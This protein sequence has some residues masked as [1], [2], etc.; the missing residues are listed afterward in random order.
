[1]AGD[2][3]RLEPWYEHL[4]E[5]LHAIIRRELGAPAGTRSPR[6][7]DAGC[8]TGLQAEILR[9]LGYRVHGADLS[10]AL[11]RRARARLAAAPLAVAPLAVA[12]V[13]ALPY[14][15]GAF[16]LAVCCGSV[17][18][19]VPAPAH[20]LAELARVLRPGG[21]L[22]VECEHRTSLDLGWGLLSSLTGDSLG[23]GLSP[24]AAWRQLAGR[25]RTSLV[26]D[27]PGYPP[28][29]LFR[30]GELLATL[31]GAGLRPV[32]AWGIHTLTN[33]IPSTIL[34]RPELPRLLR[35]PYAALRAADR[36]VARWRA[37][38]ALAN[39]LVVLAERAA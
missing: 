26:V 1:M 4:Y 21:R 9:E 17:L 35:R 5:V 39:S 38:Q 34:H 19:F 36:A 25:P 16:D 31:R 24:R 12:D 7:L 3:D 6:A 18:S 22:L 29:R 27:Y 8:G 10:P 11:L 37:P 33:L 14:R 28:L 2:Y 13:A 20:A 30:R 32:R 15:R 23:F